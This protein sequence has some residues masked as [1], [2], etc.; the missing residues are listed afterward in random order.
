MSI[1]LF[2]NSVNAQKNYNNYDK[3]WYKVTQ[4]EN[5]KLPKSALKIVDEIY[6]RAKKE[7]NAPQI[8]KVLL[9][10]SKYALTIKEDAQLNIINSFKKEIAT[11]EFPTKNILESV[12]ADLYWQYFQQ[13]RYKF[14]NRTITSEKVDPIDFRTWD[15]KTIFKEIHFHFQNSLKNGLIAQ[16]T[17]LKQFDAILDLQKNSKKFRPTLFDFLNHNAL[18]FYKTSETAI[19]QANYKFEIDTE[20]YLSSYKNFSLLETQSK[21]SLS[22]QLNALKIYQNLL[23]FHINSGNKDALISV[24]LERLKFVKEHAIFNEKEALF[25]T[26]LIALKKEFSSI[27]TATLIDFEI[28]TIYNNYANEY[29]TITNPENQFKRIEA[30]KTCEAAIEKFP[31]S[32]G[33]KNCER[34]K[35][36]IL[37]N[38]LRIISEKHIPV[39]NYSTILVTYKQ[40]DNL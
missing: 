22:L 4:F 30:I 8:A 36:Q 29:N 3:L 10:Q 27:E 18:D 9:Y 23:A 6:N 28:A 32:I 34:L 11:S 21:D 15:L 40:I 38:S 24:D 14:Y 12:L 31:E 26:A 17:D 16:Q 35:Q 2:S 25:L 1:F 39:N 5:D 37:D 19:T 7:N 20:H 33:A 13:N